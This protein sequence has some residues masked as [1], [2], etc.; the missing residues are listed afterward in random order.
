MNTV[1]FGTDGVRGPF[2]T[3]PID[4]HTC[5]RI[6]QAAGA[7]LGKHGTALIA[8]DTRHSGPELEAALA[9]GLAAAG[10]K[11]HLGGVLPTAALSLAVRDVGAAL[12]IMI[13]A[14]HNPATDNGVKLFAPEGTKISDFDQQQIERLINAKAPPAPTER[15]ASITADPAL[16]DPYLALVR[17]KIAGQPLSGLKLA[18]DCA[19]GA[20]SRWAPELL[21]EAG[22]ELVTI[23]DQPDG[24]N[25]NLKCGSTHPESLAKTVLDEGCD[26]GIAFDGDADRVLLVDEMGG[27]IDGDQILAR[28]ATDGQAAGTLTTTHVIATVMSN[29]GLA[30]YL[31]R[32]GLQ[33]ER[34]PVG[35]RH[36]AARLVELEANLGG[37][38]S[39]HILM[40][41]LLPTGDGLMAGLLPL[42]SLAGSQEPASVHLRP[43]TPLPQILHNLRHGGGRPLIEPQVKAAIFQAVRTLGTDGRVLVRASGT[44]PLIRIM[45]EA[46]TRSQAQAAIDL[47]AGTISQAGA[48]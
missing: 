13:T 44:E 24:H 32:L 45:A 4:R 23:H 48:K 2:G 37:E 5:L 46:E 1:T 33:L 21:A 47:I 11:V 35:D 18:V 40:P 26:A 43:F 15:P 6:G 12:G 42:I 22:A 7:V 3:P 30:R 14:S 38:Q 36:V 9:E 8:R 16:A 29:M 28:L 34:T 39:G 31:E 10:I 27:L 17:G 19:N 25:I 41:D 20:S